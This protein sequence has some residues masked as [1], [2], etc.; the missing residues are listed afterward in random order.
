MNKK[1]RDIQKKKEKTK[2][3]NYYFFIFST[4]NI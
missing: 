3:V 2:A 4:P 1:K